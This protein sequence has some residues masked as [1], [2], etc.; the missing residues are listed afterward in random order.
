MLHGPAAELKE[1]KAAKK[2]AKLGLRFFFVY[3]LVYVSFVFLCVYKPDLI[4]ERVFLGLNLA[5][6]YGF[7]LILLAVVMGF[8]YNFFATRLE[9]KYNGKEG[10]EV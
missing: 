3:L 10:G 1:D 6:V 2:K 5:V 4:G 8:F 9:D 7:S